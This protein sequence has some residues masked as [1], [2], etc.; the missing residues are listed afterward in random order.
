MPRRR[1]FLSIFSATLAST[2]VLQRLWN[3]PD[4]G[5]LADGASSNSTAA[6]KLEPGRSRLAMSRSWRPLPWWPV[7][8][9][10]S[11]PSMRLEVTLAKQASWPDASENV[12]IGSAGGGID[13][14]QWQ[15]ADAAPDH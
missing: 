11:L 15:I 3:A 14:G 7:W 2:L 10:A 5:G 9:K 12:V 6:A 4:R 1:R 8:N 13:G